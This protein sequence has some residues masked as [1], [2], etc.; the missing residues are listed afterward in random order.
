MPRS[1]DAAATAAAPA[2]VPTPAPAPA[3]LAVVAEPV[4]A[5]TAEL[6]LDAPLARLAR[7]LARTML[8]ATVARAA[9]G[10]VARAVRRGPLSFV[11]ASLG[12]QVDWWLGTFP[13]LAPAL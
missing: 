4:P 5:P 13:W 10:V 6:L 3:E 2:P 7:A 1:R 9:L 8:A 11:W 12:A